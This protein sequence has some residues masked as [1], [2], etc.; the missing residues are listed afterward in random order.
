MTLKEEDV[1]RIRE[2]IL[3]VQKGLGKILYVLD[4]LIGVQRDPA[5][6]DKPECVSRRKKISLE[7]VECPNCKCIFTPKTK[8]QVFCSNK[9]R[10]ESLA[11]RRPKRPKI[12]KE[13]KIQ[14]AKCAHCGKEFAKACNR[15]KFCS[16]KCRMSYFSKIG[17]ARRKAKTPVFEYTC[18]ICGNK[19]SSKKKNLTNHTC[20]QKC[21]NKHTCFV[22]YAERHPGTTLEQY[23]KYGDLRYHRRKV[24]QRICV[25]CGRTYEPTTE[26]QKYCSRICKDNANAEKKAA[27]LKEREATAPVVPKVQPEVVALP[28]KDDPR[29]WE[30][31]SCGVCG[32]T[33]QAA[34]GTNVRYCSK[35]LSHY[36]YK[37]CVELEK[38][39]KLKKEE[40]KNKSPYKVCS[41]CGTYFTDTTPTKCQIFCERC[42][43][44][45]INKGKKRK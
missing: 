8:H 11:H 45:Q 14:T 40:E 20:S 22:R 41:I 1:I 7:D 38:E 12:E 10:I 13:V 29:T 16:S 31:R 32:M 33:F 24:E 30:T 37:E 23:L 26:E 9:C 5:K 28:T 35:C 34:K 3:G 25:Y 6:E 39:E 27:T 15:Q 19:F 36:G 17:E 44:R 18:C 42:R 2:G 4:K 43:N 21:N